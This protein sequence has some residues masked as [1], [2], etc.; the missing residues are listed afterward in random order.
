MRWA[1]TP[2][3][4]A[5]RHAAVS[6]RGKGLLLMASVVDVDSHVYE[7]AGDLGPLRPRAVP[8]LARVA[9]YH[10]VDD[11]GNRLTILNGAPGA[12]LNRSR[13]VRQAIWRPGMTADDIGALD[14]DVF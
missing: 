14:P 2:M 3:S 5:R 12:E 11:E 10:E 6:L 1:S 9:F 8:A 13:L 7:P 4:L